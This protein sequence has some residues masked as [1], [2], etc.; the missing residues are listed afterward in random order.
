M[1]IFE[2]CKNINNYIIY[3]NEDKARNSLIKLLDYLKK[4][5]IEY[6]PIVNNLIRQT[7]L[8]PYMN[9]QNANWE[10]KLIFDIFKV[11]TGEEKPL[12]LHKKQSF[13]LK[14]LLN[15]EN[16]AVSAPTSFGKSF[17]IDAFISIKKP[18]NIMII[19]PTI[20]LT[21]ETRRRIQK[22]FGNE[23]K[24]ITTTDVELDEKNIFI[25]PQERAISYVNILTSLDMLVVDEFYKASSVFDKERSSSLL[26]A[27]VNLG[28]ISKQKYYLAPN[29]TKLNKNP[30]T[31]DMEFLQL[32]F[33]TVVLE[34]NEL[35]KTIKNENEK[36]KKLIEILVNNTEKT[37]IYAGT[38]SEI[39]KVSKLLLSTNNQEK[40]LLESF[41][42][43][44][45]KNYS[46]SWNLVN[47]VKQ[48][49]GIHNGQ[50]HRS[51]S[52]IQVRLFEEYDGL[53]IFISTSSI[54]E[55]V[56]TSTEK[57]IIWRSKNGQFNL[58]NFSYKNIL[59]RSGRMFKHFIGK[60]YILDKPPEEEDTQLV[61]EIPE[62]SLADFD[63]ENLKEELTQEQKNKIIEYKE[64]MNH[65]LGQKEFKK[66]LSDNTLQNNLDLIQKIAFDMYSN[67]RSWNG[68]SYLNSNNIDDWDDL[69][70]KI[71]KFQP[72]KW[73]VPYRK[74]VK[75]I[76]VL[77]FNS[78]K[79]IP[80]LL[81]MLKEVDLTVSDFFKLERLVTFNFA[82]LVSDIDILQKIILKKKK[83][84]IS[85]FVSKVS[86]AF[87]PSV[88]YLLEEYGL[89]RMLA[90][91]IHNSKLINFTDKELN[92]H[93]ALEEFRKIG[94]EKMKT[95]VSSF[96]GFDIYI[97]EN[98]Y[99][100]IL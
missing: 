8:Y 87:L 44:L 4:E 16:I 5:K 38:Y 23:Y 12:T 100:G 67:P 10:D 30:F 71:I 32:D 25:F 55:G 90:K 70:Y 99:D 57:V 79:T 82:S 34:K 13:L 26:K 19:V 74:F 63:D 46:T 40:P 54:I 91:K 83:M 37:L 68:L 3:G 66:L 77:S 64:I 24:I 89:P 58:D 7:G 86:H 69:I 84:D 18:S 9:F 42:I 27:I 28:K 59:G 52:Q 2:E 95:E 50:L 48:G 62:E 17:V 60:V 97:L 29:I 61:L 73:G 11:D 76:K 14:K 35:Y 65:I 41:S 20:A 80:S 22:K 47:L 88:V 93:M 98:F 72:N 36:S 53:N 92:I 81:H 75:F 78:H 85:P 33:N 43:W 94:I 96:D 51:L 39:G 1:E 21:D 49:I 45:A 31:K 15:S 56:N 6:S